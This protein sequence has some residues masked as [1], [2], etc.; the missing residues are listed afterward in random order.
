ME[1]TTAER[2]ASGGPRGTADRGQPLRGLPGDGRAA[3]RRRRDPRDRRRR[4][5]DHAG[6]SCATGSPRSPAG[7]RKLGVGKGDT[8]AL[9][10]N[11]RPEFIPCDLAAVALGARPVLD[12]PDLLAGADRLRLR[13]AGAQGRDR[14]DRR[15]SSASSRRARSSRARARDRRRRRAA[16]TTTLAE[17]EAVDPDFD[18]VRARR[19]GRARRPADADLH[20]RHHRSAE[21]RAAHPPQPDGADRRGRATWST[22]PERGGKVISWLPAAHIAERGAHYYLPVVHGL[23]IDDLPRPAQDRRVPAAGAADLVLRRAADLGE[24]EGRPR[25]EAGEACPTSSASR[26]RR[27]SRR[28][29]RRSALEQAGEEVPEELAAAVAAADEEMFSK[30]RATL[31]LD[32]AAGRQRRRRAHPARGARVLPRDR[33][34]GSASCGGCRRPAA[35]PPA[36]RRTR[37]SSAPSARRCPASRSSSPRT[38]RCW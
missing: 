7:S 3:R 6:T 13:D 21:G 2:Y 38:A 30:L 36:T 19:R 5:L 11:N 32:E 29:S 37:S 33:D 9:M 23:T 17:L 1:V 34:P 16:A 15:S 28:R 25:G 26:P 8:V 18:A 27:A 22:F 12:L 24:A 4:G 35:S 14:R 31:G 10:L 20:L